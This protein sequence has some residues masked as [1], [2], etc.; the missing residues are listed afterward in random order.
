MVGIILST[1]YCDPLPLLYE[2]NDGR[3]AMRTY[4]QPQLISTVFY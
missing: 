2:L 3:R 1:I 4:T